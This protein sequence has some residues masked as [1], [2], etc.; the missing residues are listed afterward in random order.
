[1]AKPWRPALV[2]A[3]A[4]L[5]SITGTFVLAYR[6]GRHARQA[7]WQNEPI[8]PWMPV[9]FIAH[10]HHLPPAVLFQAIGVQPQPHDRRSI[11]RIA[12]DQN[13]P[14]TELMDKLQKAVAAAGPAAQSARPPSGKDSR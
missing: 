13:R 10:S 8:R 12:R 14:L 3:L 2:L 7:Q 5:L 11:R 1:V 9:P 6:A 4:F